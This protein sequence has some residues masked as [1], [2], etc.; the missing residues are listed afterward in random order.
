MTPL[1]IGTRGSPLALWQAH[2]V[3]GLLRPRIAPRAVELI[4]I[5]TSGDIDRSTS[6]AQL[7][8]EGVFT[9]EIQKALLAETVDVAVHSLKDLPTVAVAGLILGAIPLRGPMG[10]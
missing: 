4:E 1:R 10:D 8:G 2:H 7:G 3:A 5:Q 6:L 9:R